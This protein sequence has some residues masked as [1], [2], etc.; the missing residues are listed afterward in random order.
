MNQK[1]YLDALK[2]AL[3][4]IDR[5]TRDNILLEIKGLISELSTQESI[6]EH[7]GSPSE[8]AKQYLD[9]E[10]IPPTVGKKVMGLG[11][12]IFL[13]IGIGITVLILALVLFGWY[14]NQDS[15]NY[16]DPNAKQLNTKAVNW[17]TVEWNSDINIEIEQGRAVLYWH[18]KS[19]I[20]WNCG[21]NQ[22]LNP[23]PNKT[24]KIRHDQCLIFLPKQA[25]KITAH[26]SDVVLVKPQAITNISLNQSKLRIAEKGV[27]YKLEINAIRSAIGDFTSYDD[28]STILN[29]KSEESQVER[30]EY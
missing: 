13:A 28:A 23:T 15:F 9:G 24:L 30:Y 6:E 8:L 5:Q 27:K 18:D 26:Q 20:S 10:N 25:I 21:D 17:N 16:A 22:N 12:K 19:S 1:Q 4:G 3:K 14:F 2:K 29:I 11:K 7:F